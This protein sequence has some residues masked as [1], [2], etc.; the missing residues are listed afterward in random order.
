MDVFFLSCLEELAQKVDEK[1]G[2]YLNMG[3]YLNRRQQDLVELVR[4]KGMVR[5]ADAALLFPNVSGRTL[6]RDF[7]LL[8]SELLI[9]RTGRGKAVSYSISGLGIAT[10]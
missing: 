10:E 6:Q 7:K 5:L 2:R 4:E 8:E 9:E 3:G 1:Y